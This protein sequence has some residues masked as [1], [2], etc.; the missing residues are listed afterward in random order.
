MGQLLVLRAKGNSTL[1]EL[2]EFTKR[3]EQHG[4]NGK[5]EVEWTL[6]TETQTLRLMIG[7]P[8]NVRIVNGKKVAVRSKTKKQKLVAEQLEE[9]KKEK[10]EGKKVGYRPPAGKKGPAKRKMVKCSVCDI[11]KPVVTVA[12]VKVVKPHQSKGEPCAGGGV[13][14]TGRSA[15][16]S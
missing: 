13:Q 5:E 15:S 8:D 16:K 10:A 3:A 4:V 1:S 11:R 9:H 2:V 14:Y 6:D 7:L 12:G